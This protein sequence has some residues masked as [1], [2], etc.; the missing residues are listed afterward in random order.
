[1]NSRMGRARDFGATLL[2][3]ALGAYYLMHAYYAGAVIGVQALAQANQQMYGIP[4]P[5]VA[6][7]FIVLG[8][9]AGGAMLVI[10]LYPRIGALLNVPIMAGAVLFVH[11]NQG[12]FMRGVVVSAAEGR[13]A[14]WGYEYTL[15]LL[16]ATV[17]AV[18][19]GGGMFTLR[20]PRKGIRISLT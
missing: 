18:F 1:M 8:H 10:G 16:I 3:L 20:S 15:F 4:F 17:A 6:A 13:A 5:V 9:L 19:L 2:R 7:W 14:A 11:L 12:F